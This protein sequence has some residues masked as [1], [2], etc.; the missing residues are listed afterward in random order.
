ML[1]VAGSFSLIK[2]RRDVDHVEHVHVVQ[3]VEGR[4]PS[5]QVSRRNLAVAA[6]WVDQWPVG[7]LTLIALVAESI[8]L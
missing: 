2:S 1:L 8:V 3:E 6:S 4:M 7:G 5:L